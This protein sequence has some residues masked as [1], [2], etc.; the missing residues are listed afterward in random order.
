MGA[1][2]MLHFLGCSLRYFDYCAN[3]ENKRL[4]FFQEF[5]VNISR[6]HVAP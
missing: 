2:S 4:T 3:F 6:W 5:M 1:N